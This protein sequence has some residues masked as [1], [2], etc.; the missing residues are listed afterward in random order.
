MDHFF[1]R[2]KRKDRSSINSSPLE[3]F[4]AGLSKIREWNE[5]LH[6]ERLHR[7]REEREEVEGK[8]N[9]REERQGEEIRDDRYSGIFQINDLFEGTAI[10]SRVCRKTPKI[11]FDNFYVF[12]IWTKQT[13]V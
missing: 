13:A 1:V 3:S 11:V 9:R 2:T 6:R 8:R 5:R 4:K 12:Q 7:E 10:F